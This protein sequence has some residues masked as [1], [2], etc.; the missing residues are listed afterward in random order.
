[1]P[2]VLQLYSYMGF[3]ITSEKTSEKT[4]QALFKKV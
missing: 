2:D 4:H 3:Q 1:L